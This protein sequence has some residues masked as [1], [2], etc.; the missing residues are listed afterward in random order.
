MSFDALEKFWSEIWLFS[1][2]EQ[3]LVPG[4]RGMNDLLQY[5]NTGVSH[6]CVRRLD[7][8]ETQPAISPSEEFLF[9]RIIEAPF[10]H[11]HVYN[12][13]EIPKRGG[14][15]ALK[16]DL[17]TFTVLGDLSVDERIRL[18]ALHNLV[19]FSSSLEYKSVLRWKR[20]A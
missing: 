1:D 16:V 10:T 19:N 4:P 13:V 8:L 20:W 6:F 5:L 2:G 9:W 14:L 7:G 11:N 3:H 15:T 12:L 17:S 18:F